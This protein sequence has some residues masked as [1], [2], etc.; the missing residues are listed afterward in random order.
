MK[1]ISPTEILLM[2]WCWF[3]VSCAPNCCVWLEG[4]VPLPVN[5]D[6]ISLESKIMPRLGVVYVYGS[7]G[8]QNKWVSFWNLCFPTE[9]VNLNYFR[10]LEVLPPLLLCFHY[11][12][13]ISS[14]QLRPSFRWFCW[15]VKYITNAARPE[16]CRVVVA[17]NNRILLIKDK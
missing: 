5:V 15:C 12:S 7:N 10:I 3:S 1:S 2:S 6:L 14:R 11:Y 8:K 16:I 4:V 13:E 17:K 9:N